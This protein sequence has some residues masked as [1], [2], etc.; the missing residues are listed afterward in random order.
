[1]RQRLEL[2]AEELA[3][4]ARAGAPSV[5]EG[6]LTGTLQSAARGNPHEGAVEGPAGECLAND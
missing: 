5:V 1:M 6:D 2:L 4:E 3:V